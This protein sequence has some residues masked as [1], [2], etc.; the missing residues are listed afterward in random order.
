MEVEAHPVAPA[1]HCFCGRRL[2]RQGGL[3][4]SQHKHYQIM[5]IVNVINIVI[6]IFFMIIISLI[7]NTC[8]IIIQGWKKKQIHNHLLLQVF[9]QSVNFSRPRRSGKI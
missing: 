9:S 4:N 8:I 2:W 6:M 3:K 1:E 7:I 5:I